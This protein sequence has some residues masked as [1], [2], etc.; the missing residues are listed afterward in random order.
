MR[1]IPSRAAARVGGLSNY[2]HL[3]G[4]LRCTDSCPTPLPER[5]ELV[6]PIES[7]CRVRS[8]LPTRT[9]RR[10]RTEWTRARGRRCL[11]NAHI[12]FERCIC[13]CDTNWLRFE[14]TCILRALIE[15]PEA[16]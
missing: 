5:E 11:R 9:G 13:C 12:R 14:L 16:N 15:F 1:R 2:D 4:R 6:H 7:A 10:D 3:A 8:P